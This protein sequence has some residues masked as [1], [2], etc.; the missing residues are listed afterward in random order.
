MVA[1]SWLLLLIAVAAVFAVTLIDPVAQDAAY[2]LFAD[3]RSWWRIPN[4]LDVL[5]NLPFVLVGLMGLWHVAFHR[6]HSLF[7]VFLAIFSG[8][9]ATG[10]GSAYYHWAPGNGTLVWDRLPMT[11][12]FMGLLTL[13]LADRLNRCWRF[14]LVPLLLTGLAS[15]WYWHATES[16]GAGDLRPYALV[17]FL[18]MLLIPLMLWLY[19]APRRDIGCYI[20]LVSCYLAAKLLEYFDRPVFEL[21]AVISGHSL[22]HLVA[23]LAT[24]F[25]YLLWK[26]HTQ[27][28]NHDS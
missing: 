25:L 5:T 9:F 22:K 27:D 7:W 13:V 19:P 3:R 15:V 23:A 8:V 21:T 10:F 11:I 26:Q 12:T 1:K 20:G 24:L 14:A 4:T 17:Q 18:P 16:A 28:E 6:Q 2:H